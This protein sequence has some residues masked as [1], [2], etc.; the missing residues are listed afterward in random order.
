MRQRL[1]VLFLLLLSSCGMDTSGEH[2][3]EVSDSTQTVK[4]ETELTLI[5]EICEIVEGDETV[6]Y[7]LWTEQQHE[8]VEKLQIEIPE[9]P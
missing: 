9:V 8:C 3:V 4:A 7:R 6:P 1:A 5:L 2:T